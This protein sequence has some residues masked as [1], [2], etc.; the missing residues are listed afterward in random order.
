MQELNNAIFFADIRSRREES[1][2]PEMFQTRKQKK[3]KSLYTW[4]MEFSAVA[5]SLAAVLTTIVLLIYADGLPL[6]R[7]NFILS[8]NAA[9]SILGAVAQLALGSEPFLQAGIYY[10]G[11]MKPLSAATGSGS[12]T[13]TTALSLLARSV[14]LDAGV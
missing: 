3:K 9:V 13:T 4:T 1:V 14:H 12:G 7:C 2:T 8:F 10:A 11:D 6:A 5:L